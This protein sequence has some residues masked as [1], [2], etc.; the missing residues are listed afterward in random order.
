MFF[1]KMLHLPISGFIIILTGFAMFFSYLLGGFYFFCDETIKR[2]NLALS[3][4]AGICLSVSPMAIIYRLDY[5]PDSDFMLIASMI[6]SFCVLAF[7]WF[8][9]RLAR[10]ELAEYYKNML[11]RSVTLFCVSVILYV[12]PITTLVRMQYWDNKEFAEI[13][14]RLAANPYNEEYKK[15][16]NQ[17]ISTHTPSGQLI[18]IKEP[19]NNVQMQKGNK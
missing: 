7:T 13:A 17:Y 12:I 18:K 14:G 6:L 10:E 8:F 11:S 4:I 5:W 19:A 1:G 3:I 9:K 2:Q 16:Y 15:Q